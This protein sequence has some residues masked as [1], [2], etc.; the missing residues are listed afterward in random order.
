MLSPT[1]YF[2]PPLHPIPIPHFEIH[3]FSPSLINR[4]FLL[5][6]RNSLFLTRR[7][8]FPPFSTRRPAILTADRSN[9][10]WILF[11][12]STSMNPTQNTLTDSHPS[13]TTIPPPL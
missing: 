13:S 3:P 10:F 5:F 7:R 6:H 2:S 9:S 11:H 1:P 4:S 12:P 8:P